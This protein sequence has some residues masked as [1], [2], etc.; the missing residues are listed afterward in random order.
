MPKLTNKGQVTVPKRIRDYLGLKPGREVEFIPVA[1]GD[2]LIKAAG[3]KPKSLFDKIRGSAAG[4]F[5]TDEIMRLT[6]GE[7]WGRE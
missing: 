4:K 7:D 1:G 2:V 5:T 3:R 6:R